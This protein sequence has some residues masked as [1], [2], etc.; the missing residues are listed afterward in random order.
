MVRIASCAAWSEDM[1]FAKWD[2]IEVLDRLS[3]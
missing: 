2:K 3:Q 1:V